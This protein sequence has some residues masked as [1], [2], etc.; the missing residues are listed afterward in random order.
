MKNDEL[1]ECV[2]N[3]SEG[4]D[5]AVIDSIRQAIVF[6]DRVAFWNHS[7]DADHNRSVFTFAGPSD[8]I[9]GAVM[10]AVRTAAELIDMETHE[11]VHP[12]I[13]AADVIPFIPLKNVSMEE[14]VSLSEKVGKRIADELELPV[15]LYAKSAKV[16]G[17][18]RLADIR[19]GGFS[20]LKQVISTD[21]DRAPDYGPKRLSSAG[22]VS[23]GA[24][25]LLIAYNVYLETNDK[26]KAQLIAKSIRESSGGFPGVQAIGLL[27]NGLAQVSMNLLNYRQTSM[28]TV[29]DAINEKAAQLGTRP[30]CSELIGMIPRSALAGTSA[31]EL[32]LYNFSIEQ[33]I[34]EH[35]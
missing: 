17:H 26:A 24:R 9:E 12:C 15:Y 3:F 32:L 2:P 22:G 25:D 23:I 4:R 1:I 33:I 8:A 6:D 19:R 27:V 20:R 16:P 13:G 35:L 14:C 30:H 11:G 29:F 28:K 31:E 21:P 34:E 5:P 10:R 7:A 18:R